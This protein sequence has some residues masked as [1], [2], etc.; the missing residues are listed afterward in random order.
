MRFS[1]IL[2]G[3]IAV[4]TSSAMVVPLGDHEAH[5]GRVVVD[6][7]RYNLVLRDTT[8]ALDTRD[9][10]TLY[11]GA[12]E[13]TNHLV[14]RMPSGP[15]SKKETD[16]SGSSQSTTAQSKPAQSTSA[17]PAETDGQR[18]IILPFAKGY[19]DMT[20]AEREEQ[21]L[22]DERIEDRIRGYGNSES[23]LDSP[24]R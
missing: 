15:G 12:S 17:K 19:F 7:P 9:F 13:S 1:A 8:H 14:K 10:A 3:V 2:V 5:G 18:P 23:W 11:G 6:D 21:K 4:T 22:K 24:E 16:K 20:P